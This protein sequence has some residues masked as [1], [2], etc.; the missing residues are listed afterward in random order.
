VGDIKT[1]TQATAQNIEQSTQ[2]FNTKKRGSFSER[3]NQSSYNTAR[4]DMA[5]IRA[6][7]AD[8]FE[9]LAA[10]ND[11]TFAQNALSDRYL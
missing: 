2:T 10:R 1:N 9:S 11:D 4:R 6:S 5:N 7:A 8:A 3:F